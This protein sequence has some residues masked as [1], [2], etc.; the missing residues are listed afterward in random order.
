MKYI[1]IGP[2]AY[3]LGKTEAAAIKN[4][5]SQISWSLLKKG[6]AQPLYTYKTEDEGAHVDGMGQIGSKSKVEEVAKYT[7]AGPYA[8]LKK[9]EKV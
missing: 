2:F 8:K 7:L 5:K 4:C 6:A 3:G 1:A 9:M